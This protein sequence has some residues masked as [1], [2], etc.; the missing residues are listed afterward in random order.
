MGIENSNG[1]ETPDGN[2]EFG[3]TPCF[4]YNHSNECK[5]SNDF[6]KDKITADFSDS[7]SS[8]KWTDLNGDPV[9]HQDIMGK[10]ESN[11]G[12]S[13]PEQFTGSQRKS[14]N[15]KLSFD[16]G[17]KDD[18]FSVDG[19]R[20]IMKGRDESGNPVTLTKDLEIPGVVP[21]TYEVTL[22]EK[23]M[24]QEHGNTNSRDFITVLDNIESLDIQVGPATLDN[25][26][27][28]TARLRDYDERGGELANWIEVCQ[29]PKYT[30]QCIIF[31]IITD[32]L[33][34]RI[35]H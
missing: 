8:S 7:K 35:A 25:V 23:Y 6:V 15:Q 4:C 32:R 5:A 30:G 20:V 10:I 13:L 22:H 33:T 19:A 28:E 26:Q 16:L 21:Q 3:C 12:F 27:L 11:H 24:T 2:N 31:S 9:A 1:E 34:L 17:L 29:E 18:L 14:Y